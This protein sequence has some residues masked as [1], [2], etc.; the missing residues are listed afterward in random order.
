MER[1]IRETFFGLDWW[2][3]WQRISSD[4]SCCQTLTWS[5][6]HQAPTHHGWACDRPRQ[7]CLETLF[8]SYSLWRKGEARPWPPRIF[9][10]CLIS[11]RLAQRPPT[12]FYILLAPL[13]LHEKSLGPFQLKRHPKVISKRQIP[14]D[15]RDSGRTTVLWSLYIYIL[16]RSR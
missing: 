13:F 4:P 3:D 9:S 1:R 12:A 6:Q 16:L 11:G 2:L 5:S 8:I 14:Q 10:C 15:H 7:R